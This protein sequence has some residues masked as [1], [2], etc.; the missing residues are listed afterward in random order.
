MAD[1]KEARRRRLNLPRAR[2]AGPA[3]G[4]PS[5]GH[6]S[7]RT[8]N[9]RPGPASPVRPPRLRLT[10]PRD[11][12]GNPIGS[13]G[14]I[15]EYDMPRPCGL[16]MLSESS[17]IFRCTD[18]V[19]FQFFRVIAK[20]SSRSRYPT[21]IL[22]FRAVTT[23]KFQMKSF[24]LEAPCEQR[25]YKGKS[26]NHPMIRRWEACCQRGVVSEVGAGPDHGITVYSEEK[27]EKWSPRSESSEKEGVETG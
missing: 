12:L 10:V 18:D 22:A 26:D 21:T 24:F 8:V 2:R 15:T 19:C 17:D 27:G 11:H 23:Y 6:L 1:S 5:S 16:G 4:L 14:S 7:A 9:R 25:R 13:V 20:P 3:G